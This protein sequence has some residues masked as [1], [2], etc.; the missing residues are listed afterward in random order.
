MEFVGAA[1][2]LTR[3]HL[4]AAATELAVPIDSLVAVLK[5]ETGWSKPGDGYIA[6]SRRPKILYE[7]HVFSRYTG[8]RFDASHPELSYTQ[9]RPGT[10]GR[11]GDPQYDRML[12]AYALDGNAALKACSWG[13]GQLMGFNFASCKFADVESM[14]AAMT[15]SERE[16]LIAMCRL[17]ESFGLLDELRDRRWADF[18]SRYNGEGYAVNGYD[19]KLASAF[20]VG[21]RAINWGALPPSPIADPVADER[22]KETSELLLRIQIGLN[23]WGRGPLAVDGRL[24]EE[25]AASVLL[26]KR[27]YGMN[28]RDS[29]EAVATA[30]AA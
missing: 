3:G 6:A 7:P 22:H 25:T 20:A 5:V 28:D 9:W 30:L 29:L 15:R 14:V 8:H 17:L 24:G 4:E 23:L 27:E 10:Y 13:L 18:A 21:I 16:Q 1:E 11:S 26:F 2:P 19:V 12:K